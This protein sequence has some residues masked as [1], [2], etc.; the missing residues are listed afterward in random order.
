[1]NRSHRLR[2]RQARASRHLYVTMGLVLL[3]VI[4]NA[5]LFCLSDDW[6]FWQRV[7]ASMPAAGIAAW[8]GVRER[9]WQER[10]KQ[11]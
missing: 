6:G 11:K 3:A 2:E 7:L 5:A 9:R 10:N 4:V 1:M 8:I